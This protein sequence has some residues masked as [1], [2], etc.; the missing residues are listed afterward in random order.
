MFTLNLHLGGVHRVLWW[1]CANMREGRCGEQGHPSGWTHW[2][3]EEAAAGCEG[4]RVSWPPARRASRVL[5]G[6]APA[7]CTP[8]RPGCCSAGGLVAESPG[9]PESEV[10]SG[11]LRTSTG[12]ALIAPGREDAG[13]RVPS[14]APVTGAP[15][16]LTVLTWVWE[17]QHRARLR[18]RREHHTDTGTVG[19]TPALASQ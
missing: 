13:G 8:V 4:Q 6:P 19:T 15:V 18:L 2:C 9:P 11:C 5:D 10:L 17:G 12:R 16:G 14:A 1:W 7:V 3:P